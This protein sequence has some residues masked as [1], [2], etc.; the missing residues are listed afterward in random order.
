[1]LGNDA[2]QSPP[3]ESQSMHTHNNDGG[4][5][6]LNINSQKSRSKPKNHVAN[7]STGMKHNAANMNTNGTCE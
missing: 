2:A 1:M 4:I 6:I 3:L 5:L 7:L